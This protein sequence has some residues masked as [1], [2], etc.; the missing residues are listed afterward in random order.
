MAVDPNWGEF[1]ETVQ[2]DELSVASR[3]DR[4]P[5]SSFHR[6]IMWILGFVVFFDFADTNSFAYAAPAILKFWRLPISTIAQVTSATFLGMFVGATVG[7]WLSD[8][9]GRKKALILTTLWYGAASLLDAFVW[10]TTSLL[11]V[12]LL[13]GVGISAMTVVGMTYISEMFPS[14]YRGSYQGWVMTIGLCGIPVTAYIARFC[15]PAVPWG[16]RLVFVWGS[17]SILFPFLAG[18]LEESPRWYEKHGRLREAEAALVRIES[19]VEREVGSL[20]P[21]PMSSATP[22]SSGRYR[23]LL[24]RAYFPRTLELSLTWI[25]QTLGFFGFTSWVPTLLVAHGFS[26]VHSLAWSSVMSIAAVPGAL[27]AALLA[28]HWDRRWW[29]TVFA[30]LIAVCGLTY[31]LTFRVTIIII[32]GFLVELFLHTLNP[33]L[34]AYTAECY[35]TEIRNS[36]TGLTYGAGRLANAFG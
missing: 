1:V 31:G 25:C 27:I 13:T 11:V 17:L 30:L 4:L 19:V 23:H 2:N 9:I 24:T 32:F 7:G 6:R 15:I 34:Y 28:D 36:G 21:L 8:R 18:Y 35:P 33:L 14:K 26:L 12:R 22:S 29:I 10:G 3:L 16:W 5:I 20:P